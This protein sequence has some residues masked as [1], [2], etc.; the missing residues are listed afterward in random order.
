MLQKN[1][2]GR[3]SAAMTTEIGARFQRA[4]APLVRSA[5]LLISS[6]VGCTASIIAKCPEF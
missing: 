3:V 1:V 4:Y 2:D 5:N 6:L